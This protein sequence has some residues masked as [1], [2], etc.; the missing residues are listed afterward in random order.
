M[1]N[2]GELLVR[3]GAYTDAHS[4]CAISLERAHKGEGDEATAFRL[5][6]EDVG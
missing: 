6:R 1:L 2:E 4:K 5:V 3:G